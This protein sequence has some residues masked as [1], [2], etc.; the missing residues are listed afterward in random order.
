MLMPIDEQE[1]ISLRARLHEVSNQLHVA[2]VR[3]EVTATKLDA[4]VTHFMRLDAQ[5]NRIEE[6]VHDLQRAKAHL[7]GRIVALIGSISIITTFILWTLT[8]WIAR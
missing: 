7:D 5:L 6:S 4:L 3:V 8:Q 1:L 2:T